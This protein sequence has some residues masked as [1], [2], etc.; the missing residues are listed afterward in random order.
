MSNKTHVLFNKHTGMYFAGMVPST[1]PHGPHII[2]TWSKDRPLLL[3]GIE[4]AQACNDIEV[5]GDH[6]S[7]SIDRFEVVKPPSY[8]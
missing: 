8:Y 6:L 1:Y 7:R 4:V 2:S 5:E 3:C